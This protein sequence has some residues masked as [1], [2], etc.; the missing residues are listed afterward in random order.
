MLQPQHVTAT[1][2][3]SYAWLSEWQ[4][5]PGAMVRL[6]AR[7]PSYTYDKKPTRLVNTRLVGLVNTPAVHVRGTYS[8]GAAHEL[9]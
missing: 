5:F 8:Y 2:C 1:F 7:R 3:M 9:I 6:H 4:P